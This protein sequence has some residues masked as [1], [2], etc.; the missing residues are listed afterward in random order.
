[1]FPAMDVDGNEYWLIDKILSKEIIP[2]VIITEY[3][4]SFLDYSITVPYDK[5]FDI[6]RQQSP[7]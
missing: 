7:I 5:D 2:E 6:S 4:A 3:N 1:M